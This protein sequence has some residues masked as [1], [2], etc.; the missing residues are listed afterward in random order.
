M[1]SKGKLD[2]E[3]VDLSVGVAAETQN[4]VLTVKPTEVSAGSG[5]VASY[6]YVRGLLYR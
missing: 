6:W 5:G 4:L 3:D 1:A 2:D